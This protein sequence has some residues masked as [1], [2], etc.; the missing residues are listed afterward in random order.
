[1]TIG[2]TSGL[3]IAAA[4][5][6]G[7][8]LVGG[9]NS[10]ESAATFIVPT[11]DNVVDSADGVLSLREALAAASANVAADEIVLGVGETYPITDYA[12]GA[13]TH[14]ASEELTLTGDGSH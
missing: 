2:R 7:I 5:L 4:T 9:L 11:T 1:M 12:A 3:L 14:A 10:P 6:T 13:L 8:A